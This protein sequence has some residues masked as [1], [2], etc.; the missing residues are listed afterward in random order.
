MGNVTSRGPTSTTNCTQRALE[1][2]VLPA[3]RPERDQVFG[4]R[5]RDL[6]QAKPRVRG[7]GNAVAEGESRGAQ[8]RQYTGGGGMLQ[9]VQTEVPEVSGTSNPSGWGAGGLKKYLN[10]KSYPV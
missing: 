6:Q 7:E 1:N 2:E 5:K 10:A 3:M 9:R 8:F 4:W